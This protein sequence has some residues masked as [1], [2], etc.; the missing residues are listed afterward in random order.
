MSLNHYKC[1][2]KS[3]CE[4]FHKLANTLKREEQP[5]T[6]PYPWLAEDDERRNLA[7]REILERNIDLKTSCLIQKEKEEL[8]D[9]LY[10]YKD[11]FSLRDEI[12]TCPNIE[13][14]IDVVVVDK[15][16]FVIRLYHL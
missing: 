3:L 7:D 14:E 16:P 15:T 10:R 9:M 6:G 8:M 2:W 1:Y 4:G 12:G 11:E 5:S 13:V